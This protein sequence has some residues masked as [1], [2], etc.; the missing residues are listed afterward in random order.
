MALKRPP[1]ASSVYPQSWLFTFSDMVTLLL[2]FFVL[3]I[4]ITT[5]DPKS[6]SQDG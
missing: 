5:T 1:A 2:T 4:S 3:I 6:F